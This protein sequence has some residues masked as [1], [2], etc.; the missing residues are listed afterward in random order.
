MPAPEGDYR[1]AVVDRGTL[2]P[3]WSDHEDHPLD[4]F[5]LTPLRFGDDEVFHFR[6]EEVGCE[7]CPEC[8]M[9]DRDPPVVDAGVD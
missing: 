8:C 4:D 5:L 6:G 3:L 1:L 9:G 2:R 7:G